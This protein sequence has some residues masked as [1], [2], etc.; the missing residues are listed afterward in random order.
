MKSRFY[1]VIH[2]I[3]AGFLRLIFRLHVYGRENEPSEEEGP[4]IIASNH[5]SATDPIFLCA[6]TKKQQPL[7]M[8]KKELFGIPVLKH[9]IRK[10]G[11]FPVDRGGA[12]VGAVKKAIKLVEEGHCLGIFPQGKRCNGVDPRKTKVKAG[13]GMVAAH[14]KAQILPVHIKTKNYQKRFMRRIDIYIGKPI[15]FDELNY[16]S[17]VSGEYLRMSEYVFD[18]I[19]ELGENADKNG[20]K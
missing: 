11:A 1:I 17:E 18:K 16:N 5:I 20:A 3:F 9:I 12:D 19:C 14:T 4:Y 6:A 10:F 13:V 7:F 15:K 8:A 2:F